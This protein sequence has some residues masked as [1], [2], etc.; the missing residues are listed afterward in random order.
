MDLKTL[1]NLLTFIMEVVK[2]FLQTSTIHG[3]GYISNTRRYVRLLWICVIISGFI[4]A[5]V[6][7]QQSLS[8]WATSPVSTTIETLPISDFIFPNVT[9]CPPRNSF[10][11]LNPDLVRARNINFTAEQREELRILADRSVFEENRRA[12]YQDY[13]DFIEDQNYLDF[14]SGIAK[15]QFPDM[16]VLNEKK[17]KNFEFHTTSYSGSI[18]T[19]HF[20][21]TFQEENF[22]LTLSVGFFIN[23]PNT[24]V[25][26]AYLEISIEYDIEKTS[27]SETIK[28]DLDDEPYG[29]LDK[30]RTKKKIL[31]L[32]VA[33]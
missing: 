6:L 17:F 9:V 12:K 33:C 31:F 1:S 18:S 22:Y 25:E 16:K 32:C 28:I 26:E 23:V 20:G 7:I 4:G 10:T 8:S 29:E 3:L 15:I 14:Y 27:S 30:T 21:Q 2:E 13:L 11:S 24:L 5:G 19:P